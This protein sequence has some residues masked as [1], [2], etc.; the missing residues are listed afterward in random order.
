M[1]SVVLYVC[2]Q[3]DSSGSISDIARLVVSEMDIHPSSTTPEEEDENSNNDSSE[4]KDAV[5][6]SPDMTANTIV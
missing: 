4:D 3:D 2:W 6:S 5:D 1:L